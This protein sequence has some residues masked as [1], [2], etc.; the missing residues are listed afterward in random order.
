V[1]NEFLYLGKDGFFDLSDSDFVALIEGPLFDSLRPDK[2]GLAQNLHMFAQGGLTQVELTC[3]EQS[4]NAVLHQI[5]VHLWWEM[6]CRLLKP[7]QDLESAVV[8]EGSKR[9]SRCHRVDS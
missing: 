3:D 8:R 9:E 6:L 7:G 5:T 2:S 4:A 1:P